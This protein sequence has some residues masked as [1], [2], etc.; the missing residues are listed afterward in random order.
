MQLK[1]D[2]RQRGSQWSKQKGSD[3]IELKY[4]EGCLHGSILNRPGVIRSQSQD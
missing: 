2:A 3:M 4:Q 1:S